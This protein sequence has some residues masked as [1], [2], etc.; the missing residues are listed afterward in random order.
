[1]FPI[2]FR[3]GGEHRNRADRPGGHSQLKRKPIMKLHHG[4]LR[5]VHGSALLASLIA[6]TILSLALASYLALS[7]KQSVSVARSQA[8]NA[9]I[10]VA[11]SGVEEALAQL[12]RGIGAAA[13]NLAANGWEQKSSGT[14]GPQQRRNIGLSSYD[15]VIVEGATPVIYS[16]GY[17]AAPFGGSPISR[18]VQV[19]TLSNAPL[20]A[21]AMVAKDKID[22]KGF[23]TATDSFDSAD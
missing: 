5:N 2:L 23:N 8:W 13:L 18:V 10:P 9:A 21:V 7:Q 6:T 16:T 15:V 19:T 14:Y 3:Q 1:M 11:E 4:Q 22:F 17:C 20:F 12:N